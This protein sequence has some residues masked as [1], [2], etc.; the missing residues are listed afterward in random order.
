MSLPETVLKIL[1]K[2]IDMIGSDDCE[3]PEEDFSNMFKDTFKNI[4][5]ETSK[6]SKMDVNELKKRLEELEAENK[7]LRD[8]VA[9]LENQL[10]DKI[11]L[12]LD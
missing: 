9:D 6:F 12:D 2:S 7:L 4:L 11:V 1:E 10:V 3:F 5:K 8:R